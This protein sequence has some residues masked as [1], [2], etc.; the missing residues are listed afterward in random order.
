MAIDERNSDPL[1]DADRESLAQ[2]L[3]AVGKRDE[4]FDL[5]RK[6]AAGNTA[7]VAARSFA[8]LAEMDRE[9]AET[10]YRNA[11]ASEE[12]ASGKDSPRVAV[13]LQE[14]ALTL[15]SA[16]RDA[17]AEPLLRRALSIQQ[18]AVKAEPQVTIGILNT[19]GNLLEG[20]KKPDEAEKLERTALALSEE[21]LGPESTLLAM[22]CTNL[23]DVL[24]NK[25]N[26]R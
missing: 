17:E 10:H 25:K 8:K 18:A 16:G 7:T 20:A 21:K 4:A 23:A 14:Y 11:V 19:L 12:K 26:L 3:E 6:A 24:W 5:Y 15:R 13:L 22:T 9:H 1:I 2:T